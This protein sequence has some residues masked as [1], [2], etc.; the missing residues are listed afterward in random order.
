M[1]RVSVR[2]GLI[3]AALLGA[4]AQ[5]TAPEVPAAA[6]AALP[7]VSDVELSPNGKLLAGDDH[8]LSKAANRLEVLQDTDRFLRQYLK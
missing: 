1:V 6:F 5:A 2:A 4:S 8:W 7:Q 3:L